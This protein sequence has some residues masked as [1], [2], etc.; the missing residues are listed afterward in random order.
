M[1]RSSSNVEY[2]KYCNDEELNNEKYGK[3]FKEV[4]LVRLSLNN[5]IVS[6]FFLIMMVIIIII[7]IYMLLYCITLSTTLSLS[8]S[9]HGSGADP[10]FCLRECEKNLVIKKEFNEKTVL[11]KFSI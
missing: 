7:I 2:E 8:L 4:L 9:M 6:V 1:T 11:K 3:T 10:K 5:G